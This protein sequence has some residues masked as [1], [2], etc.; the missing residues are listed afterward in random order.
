MNV[1]C[2]EGVS[3]ESEKEKRNRNQ[4]YFFHKPKILRLGDV[5]KDNDKFAVAV[6]KL[7]EEETRES[8]APPCPLPVGR[9]VMEL[10]T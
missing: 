1:R 6:V 7:P 5:P 8:E 10:P 4:E 2:R 3:G 9:S